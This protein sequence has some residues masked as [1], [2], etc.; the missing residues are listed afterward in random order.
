MRET[1]LQILYA[2]LGSAGFAL[3]FGQRLLS[4]VLPAA[5]GGA[6]A[7][8]VYLISEHFGADVFFASLAAGV[9]SGLWGEILARLMKAPATVFQ[10]VAV[11]PLVPGSGLYY[12]M[13]SILR[14]DWADFRLFGARTLFYALGI[15]AGLAVI[16][17]LTYMI[18]KALTPHRRKKRR[19]LSHEENQTGPRC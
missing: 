6:L 7:W 12:T 17:A 4:R 8:A 18:T 9:F 2:Y 10:A 14:R 16:S 11:I 3:I 19:S 1:L 15:A 13:S 5:L